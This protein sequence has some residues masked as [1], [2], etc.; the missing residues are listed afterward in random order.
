[1]N[2]ENRTHGNHPSEAFDEPLDDEGIPYRWSR[3]Q[4]LRIKGKHEQG[5]KGEDRADT[6]EDSL[7]VARMQGR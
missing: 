6:S 2:D 4:Y 3:F 1:M 7:P 5:Q